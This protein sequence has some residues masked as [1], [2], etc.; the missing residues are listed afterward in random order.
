MKLKSISIVTFL[1]IL[2]VVLST[3]KALAE[4]RR[5]DVKREENREKRVEVR[6][7]KKIEVREIRDE[8]GMLIK[9]LNERRKMEMNDIKNSSSTKS[10][11]KIEK[12]ELF[13]R[14][15]D[16]KKEIQKTAKIAEFKVRKDALVGQL[17]ITLE[18][19]SN[20]RGR[21]NEIIIKLEGE[22]KVMTEARASLVIA[23]DKLAKAKIAV[24]ALET[25]TAPIAN[26]AAV[27]SATAEVDLSKPRQ[28]GDAAI[29]AVKDARDA[30]KKVYELLPKPSP[31]PSSAI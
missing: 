23:D 20:S 14:Y 11:M 7:Q 12:T 18:N 16:S 13:K 21:I 26:G 15:A 4:E 8:K 30:L 28:V 19:L 22:G 31:S 10:M 25:L 1:L 2:T 29:K 3:S 24:K 6:D 5:V 27:D 9:D 17:N